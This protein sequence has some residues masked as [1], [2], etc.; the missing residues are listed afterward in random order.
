MIAAFPAHVAAQAFAER[1]VNCVAG[2]VAIALLAG[3]LLRLTGRRNAGTR[4]A[5]WYGILLIVAALPFL[6]G[7]VSTRVP[8]LARGAQ[9]EVTLPAS[10]AFFWLATWGVGAAVGLARICI[11]VWR[12]R[13]LRA[14]ASLLTPLELDPLV[15]KTLE[16]NGSRRAVAVCVSPEVRVP[17]AIGFFRPAVLIPSW[18]MYTLPPAELNAILLHELAHLQR[19]DDWTNLVEKMVRA[20]FFF[21]PAVWW[22]GSRLSLLREMACDDLVLARTSNPKAYAEC[23]ISLAEKSFLRRGLALANAAVNR[24]SETSLRV[25]EILDANRPAATRICKP[26]LGAMAMCSIAMVAVLSRAPRLVGFEDVT[27]SS[28]LQPAR[29]TSRVPLD[30][31]VRRPEPAL[32]PAAVRTAQATG[33]TDPRKKP[34]PAQRPELQPTMAASIRPRSN[35]SEA[36]MPIVVNVSGAEYASAPSLLV[37]METRTYYAVDGSVWSVWVWRV[38]AMS[39]IQKAVP[40]GVPAKST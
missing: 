32:I 7:S 23:L 30:A 34:L 27:P 1:M 36:A 12:V 6:T 25:A 3:L 31:V 14:R 18:A 4:F 5:V 28:T 29:N 35:G 13:K 19:W 20:I 10:W 16:E 9:P 24:M 22:A 39:P 15:R 37:V 8:G 40:E 2:G 38:R 26:A 21:H 11:G 17:A 33:S